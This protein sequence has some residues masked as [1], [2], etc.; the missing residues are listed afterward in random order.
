M[1][2]MCQWGM[3]QTAEIE[4]QMTSVERVMEYANLPPE[5]PLESTEANKP[6]ADWPQNGSIHFQDLNFKYSGNSEYVL[7]DINVKV[8]AGEKIGIVGRTGAGKSSII[9]A[10]FRLAEL[11]GT[12]LIDGVDTSHLGL[13]DLRTK[14]SIIPQDPV[15]FSGTLRFNLD[16]FDERTEA[17]LWGALAQVYFCKLKESRNIIMVLFSG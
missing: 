5:P 11:D 6:P 12:I 15:L 4:N 14:I 9:Q 7:R 1:I 8:V 10:L 3:R 16:P 2:G 13:H 17:E